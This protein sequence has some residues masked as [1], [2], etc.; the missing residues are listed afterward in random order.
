MIKPGRPSTGLPLPLL[1][2]FSPSCALPS[3]LYS[4]LSARPSIHFSLHLSPLSPLLLSLLL[5]PLCLVLLSPF[6]GPSLLL[7]SP[8]L[9]LSVM[10]DLADLTRPP[11]W[12]CPSPPP[13]HLLSPLQPPPPLPHG[14][15]L[16]Y[17]PRRTPRYSREVPSRLY[18][19]HRCVFSR[20]HA[21]TRARARTLTM[22]QPRSALTHAG[23]SSTCRAPLPPPNAAAPRRSAPCRAA[24]CSGCRA[25]GLAPR[26][27]QRLLRA[28]TSRIGRGS[29]TRGPLR[30]SGSEQ[31]FFLGGGGA[32][33]D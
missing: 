8:P 9:L 29:E 14:S 18:C 32:V 30:P 31:A 16:R 25:P 26:R 24:Q 17:S 20:A 15:H 3:L 11:L 1:P 5:S 12:P 21:R 19:P 28:R 22:C 10:S 4:L 27:R 13:T 2:L 23:S 7:S 33:R 6:P